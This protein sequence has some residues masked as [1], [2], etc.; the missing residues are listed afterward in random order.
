[1]KES[2]CPDNPAHIYAVLEEPVGTRSC[3][4][5][6]DNGYA[7]AKDSLE[8]IP[9]QIVPKA[10]NQTCMVT[11]KY[12]NVE[13]TNH[14]TAARSN[15][16]LPQLQSYRPQDAQHNY[17]Q[18]DAARHNTMQLGQHSP[19][20][21]PPLPPTVA[22]SSSSSS[23][24]KTHDTANFNFKSRQ[25]LQSSLTRYSRKSNQIRHNIGNTP[26]LATSPK[27]RYNRPHSFNEL[28]APSMVMQH[29]LAANSEPDYDHLGNQP[30]MQQSQN[31]H[32]QVVF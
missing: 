1:M 4:K 31:T 8:G 18:I 6:Q 27:S 23:L 30:V 12:A 17:A 19:P 7:Q 15:S 22:S 9:L 11:H 29:D 13:V 26:N 25:P 28:L 2:S 10:M 20:H 3:S 14:P 24:S 5:Q 32:T 16:A 21:P